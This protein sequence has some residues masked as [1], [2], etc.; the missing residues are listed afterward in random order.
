MLAIDATCMIIPLQGLLCYTHTVWN[1]CAVVVFCSCFHGAAS[2]ETK[3]E[4]DG[5]ILAV[6]CWYR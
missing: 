3:L 1:S 6:Y 2:D 5:R 4:V